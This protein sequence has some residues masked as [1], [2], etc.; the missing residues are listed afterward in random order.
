MIPKPHSTRSNVAS[1]KSKCSASELRKR[2]TRDGTFFDHDP[3]PAHF[4]DPG[5]PAVLRSTFQRAG[6]EEVT[7][8][9]A[10]EHRRNSLTQMRPFLEQMSEAERE[11][12][13]MKRAI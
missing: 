4:E 9:A 10:L 3:T 8:A 11:A 1:G 12:A 13:G 7:V 6:L 5:D 2:C